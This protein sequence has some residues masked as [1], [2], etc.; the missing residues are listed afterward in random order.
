LNS[1]L[2][3]NAKRSS[4][5]EQNI[6]V[7]IDIGGTKTAV[8]LSRELPDILARLEFQTL[9]EFG[10]AHAMEKILQGVTDLLTASGLDPS[11]IAAIGVS[12]G[13]PLD[14]HQ[15]IIQSPPNLPSWVDVPIVQILTDHFG[16]ACHLENDA[17]AGAVAEHRF[18]AGRGSRNMIFLTMG[19]GLGAGMVL[20]GQLYRGASDMAGELGHVRLTESGPVGHN[21]AGSVEGWVSGSGMAQAALA[22]IREATQRGTHTTLKPFAEKGI[23]TPRHIAAAA[24]EG[25]EVAQEIIHSTGERLGEALAILI[26]IL[27]PECIV[28]GG[29]AMRLGEALLAPA[30]AVLEREALP[31]SARACKLVAAALGESIGDVAAL[32]VATGLTAEH[33]V[34][35]PARP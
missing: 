30:R 31:E 21:K 29:L 22:P 16:V 27:N 17:N 15:G 13:G 11:D 28:M 4:V 18:G 19:T 9:P 20:N 3:K 5:H 25:D 23:L 7:G 2:S 6:L 34:A 1:D 35:E 33:P 8:V 12:C 14:R 26:D 10:P 24:L 32:C